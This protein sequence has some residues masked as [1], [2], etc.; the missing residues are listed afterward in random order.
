M[1]SFKV[2][3]SGL[4]DMLYFKNKYKE[5][6]KQI[7]AGSTT[8]LSGD[9]L[10][11]RKAAERH[12]AE[13]VFVIED[14]ID[15]ASDAKSYVLRRKD[16]TNPAFFRA[17]QFV[18]VRQRIDGKLIA[19]P[20]TLSCGPAMTLTGKCMITVK[21]VP[22]GFLSG[23]IHDNWKV[24]M[25]VV[26][27]GP[28]GNG[29]Y[30]GFRDAEHV[31]ACIGGSGITTAFSFANAIADGDEDFRLTILY[32]SQTRKDIMFAEEFEELQKRSD[33][34]RLI[35]VLSDE[36][37]EGYEHGFI[38][39]E[40]IKKYA[41]EGEY[42]VFA[43]GPQNMYRFLD[44]EIEKIGLPQKFYRKEL[45]GSL[46]EPW[47]LPG[48]PQEAKGKTFNCHVIMPGNREYNIPVSADESI[49]TAFERAGVAGPNRCRGGICGWCRS[50]LLG[51]Q[52]FIPEFV[53]GRREA[54]KVYGYI[55]PCASFALSD[56]ILDVPSP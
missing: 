37:P 1:A 44:G 27:S 23:Y 51:G 35:N 15:R 33:K 56:I 8:P 50:K 39:A 16:Q 17:G 55:H 34:I 29:Y 46:K 20:V 7:A 30:E 38:T 32:G 40:L 9:I 49:I 36:A 52:V 26:T 28:Q 22:D 13:Q 41:G 25:E 18:V 53:D 14:V 48:Y 3:A 45:F 24:G 10:L 4:T 5:R 42:S 21:R 47:T 31:V 54:D 19:R 12:P 6:E 2:G 43:A 11:N